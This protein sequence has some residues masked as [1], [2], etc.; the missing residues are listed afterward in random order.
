M[1]SRIAALLA[2]LVVGALVGG[3]GVATVQPAASG[4]SVPSMTTTAATGCLGDEP[5]AWVGQTAADA[6]DYRIVHL[7]NYSFSH[8]TPDAGIRGDVTEASDGR[9]EL[10]LTT[11]GGA[12]KAPDDDCQP[13]TT[14]SASVALP[15]DFETLRVT[16][17]G[18]EVAVIEHSGNGPAFHYLNESAN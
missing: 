1:D 4:V 2:G 15:S 18:E 9:W 10:A 16:V 7:Q 12:T 3:L 6:G 14:V 17:D 5:P 8:D 11:E 13:R